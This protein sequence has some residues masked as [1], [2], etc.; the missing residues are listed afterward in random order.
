MGG[1]LALQCGA[2]TPAG[3][4]THGGRASKHPS[5]FTPPGNPGQGRVSASAALLSGTRPP[6][7]PVRARDRGSKQRL[8]QGW[9]SFHPRDT[10]RE[11]F[12]RH[13][14]G[15]KRHLSLIQA[16]RPPSGTSR[17]SSA[18]GWDPHPPCSS[19]P[20]CSPP[21]RV[22]SA[23]NK[24]CLRIIR[25]RNKTA[26]FCFNMCVKEKN[27]LTLCEKSKFIKGKILL[28]ICV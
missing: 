25:L 18:P 22:R 9:S 3:R 7:L 11:D 23:F 15:R 13:E 28:A 8:F 26:C 12:R 6:F 19:S 17:T 5:R 4:R 14:R 24:W 20:C 1:F 27:I 10:L 16:P 2:S 21:C